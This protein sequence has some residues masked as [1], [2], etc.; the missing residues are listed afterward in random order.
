MRIMKPIYQAVSLNRLYLQFIVLSFIACAVGDRSSNLRYWVCVCVWIRKEKPTNPSGNP[1]YFKFN[2]NSNGKSLYKA[3][4]SLHT[5]QKSASKVLLNIS[6][7]SY[8]GMNASI[9]VLYPVHLK[10]TRLLQKFVLKWHQVVSSYSQKKIDQNERTFDS[11]CTRM[12][13]FDVRNITN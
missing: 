8:S 12:Q 4:K 2:D 9:R 10:R 7:T 3:H 5:L 13:I 1:Y 6:F 11:D